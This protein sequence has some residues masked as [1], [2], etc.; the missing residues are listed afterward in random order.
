MSGTQGAALLVAKIVAHLCRLGLAVV[1][2]AAGVLKL[3]DPAGFARDV[4]DYGIVSGQ[5]A[6]LVAYTLL[7]LE[8]ALGTALLLSY[9]KVASLLVTIG[10]L[11]IF[12]GAIAFAITTDQPIQGCGCFGAGASRTPVQTLTEDIGFLAAGVFA[13]MVFRRDRKEGAHRAPDARWKEVAVI[14]IAAISAGFMFLAPGLPLDDYATRLK[15]NIE[16]AD[17]EIPI[18]EMDLTRGKHLVA[19]LDLENGPSDDDLAALNGLAAEGTSVVGLYEEDESVYT[20]FFWERGPAFPLYHV[21]P[22]ELRSLYRTRPRYFGLSDGK[23]VATWAAPP[24]RTEVE[25]AARE[26]TS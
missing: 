18:A 19:I 9:R 12:I 16:W 23:V 13:V 11:V 5:S 14:G 8:V 7:P 4:G 22:A 10:L 26:G 20:A 15:A 2:L 3:L 17:L 6:T 24:T 25:T 1:F 21:T